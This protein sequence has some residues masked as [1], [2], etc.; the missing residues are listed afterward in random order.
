MYT[1]PDFDDATAVDGAP[2]ILKVFLV[3]FI[4]IAIFSL[5]R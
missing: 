5:F 4:A 1:R 2:R 3:A